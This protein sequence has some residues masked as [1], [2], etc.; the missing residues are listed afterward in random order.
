MHAYDTSVLRFVYDHLLEHITSVDDPA[1]RRALTDG[2]AGVRRSAVRRLLATEDLDGVA[3]VLEQLLSKD[4]MPGVRKEALAILAQRFPDRLPALLPRAL[5]DPA[6]RVRELAR[7]I[8]RDRQ[9]P[10]VPRDFYVEYLAS[11]A[12]RQL[13]AAI[14]GLGE[15]GTSA[16]LSLL[17]AF[18]QAPTPRVRRARLRAGA[19]LDATRAIWPPM[20]RSSPRRWPISCDSA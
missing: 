17:D 10:I 9:A 13:I 8:V 4:R 14:D 20:P 3:E 19:K 5:L 1:L 11:P 16:D 12:P 6:A 15:T 7:F 18:A 2:A